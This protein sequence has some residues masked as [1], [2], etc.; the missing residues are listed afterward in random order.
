MGRPRDFFEFDVRASSSADPQNVD[1]GV[2]IDRFPIKYQASYQM[3]YCSRS[4]RP[5]NF[6]QVNLAQSAADEMLATIGG[7]PV[8]SRTARLSV[9]L[10]GPKDV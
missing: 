8:F 2:T 3:I 5:E 1:L 4:R 9:I 10:K 6:M 7:G